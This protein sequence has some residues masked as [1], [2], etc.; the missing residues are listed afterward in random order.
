MR[1]KTKGHTSIDILREISIYFKAD[2]T[3]GYHTANVKIPESKGAGDIRSFDFFDGF[4]LLIFNLKLKEN[5]EIVR[6]TSEQDSFY[7]IHSNSGSL[8]YTSAT[9]EK[10]E[11]T[12][13]RNV[14]VKIKNKS[15]GSF[16][17]PA[18]EPIQVSFILLTKK[19]LSSV[20]DTNRHLLSVYLNDIF[21]NL[22][23]TKAFTH[24]GNLIK[25]ISDFAKVFYYNTPI[26]IVSLLT[27]KAAALN[28]LATSIE[29]YDKSKV[30]ITHR[31]PLSD[32]DLKK[33]IHISNYIANNLNM[34]L[35]IDELEKESGINSKKIQIGF[36][37]LFNETI[38]SFTRSCKFTEA[39][40]LLE[41]TNLSM[42]EISYTIGISSKSYFSKTFKEIYGHLPSEHRS[43]QYYQEKDIFQLSYRSVANIG[44]LTKDLNN[45][46]D[47]S[48]EHN[49]NANING[50]LIYHQNSFF[51][52]LEGGKKEVLELYEKIGRDPRH[53]N[54]KLLWK[55]FKQEKIFKQ[56]NMAYISEETLTLLSK[57]N[58]ADAISLQKLSFLLTNYQEPNQ[59]FW[60]NVR[61]HLLLRKI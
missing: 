21:S 36:R 20:Y 49:G 37:F 12:Q 38:N 10:Q 60:E 22:D 24:F 51:Q 43:L 15:E 3:E 4:S 54:V 16:L 46:V 55:G 23:E 17:F 1:L 19:M 32:E 18:N 52:I 8:K 42:S 31:N 27:H 48:K 57:E 34:N 30:G 13:F 11:I 44:L 59:A 29:N 28:I 61:N 5:F 45:I 14:I 41:T 2:F 25:E 26:N 53:T 40:R 6:S 39:K 33:V 7:F 56:W 47:I 35:N 50:C 58:K 9:G